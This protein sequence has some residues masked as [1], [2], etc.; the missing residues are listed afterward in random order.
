VTEIRGDGRPPFLQ[1]GEL[2]THRELAYL[3]AARDI[4]LR[5]S[6]TML[7]FAWAVLQPLLAMLLATAFLGRMARINGGGLPYAVFSITGFAVWLY[8]TNSA[9]AAAN[10]FVGHEGM[11]TR[12]Y[13]PRLLAPVAAV[14]SGL[15]DLGVALVVALPVLALNG[16]WPNAQVLL[17]P[18]AVGWLTVT[19]FAVGVWLSALNVLYRDVR[20]ILPYFMQ[21]WLF[22]S[23][24]LFAKD[25]VNG[26]W[27]YLYGVNPSVA[28]IDLIRWSLAGGT[29]PDVV[30]IISA[31]SGLLL[32]LLGVMYFRR[33]ERMFADVI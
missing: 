33:V 30:D 13:F 12:V 3:L 23:P 22:V 27:R 16:V 9:L 26:A 6:Q 14:G 29:A 2:W 4:K 24:V 10:S 19:T 11:V 32:G 17:L 28:P 5:Y 18:L 25:V 31:A 15:L 8:F 20:Y 1:L 21:V 7:G